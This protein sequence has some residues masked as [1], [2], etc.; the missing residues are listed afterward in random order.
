MS[1]Q[2]WVLLL[3]VCIAL[4]A[5]GQG[6]CQDVVEAAGV[7]L[8]SLPVWEAKVDAER[9]LFWY[10][11]RFDAPVELR[12]VGVELSINGQPVP[13]YDHSASPDNSMLLD[14]PKERALSPQ[15][16]LNRRADAA[17]TFEGFVETFQNSELI[18]SLF[19][20]SESLVSIRWVNSKHPI[21]E[22]VHYDPGP[23][24][25]PALTDLVQG[26]V[27]SIADHL[28]R[29]YAVWCNGIDQCWWTKSAQFTELPSWAVQYVENPLPLTQADDTKE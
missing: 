29:G 20:V 15:Q 13:L 5:A 25:R 3:S 9:P 11:N 19:I 26:T 28:D 7:E 23:R 4:L 24:V 22:S 8:A 6:V 18:D 14:P 2:R 17:A 1:H 21:F 27:E 10:G 12:L 16:A